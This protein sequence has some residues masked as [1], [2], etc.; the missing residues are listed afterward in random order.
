MAN[1]TLD[2]RGMT[3]QHCVNAVE[4]S[5]GALDG[6]DNVNVDLDNGKV[7]VDYD[8]SKA[9]VENIRDAIEEQ[10]YEVIPQQDQ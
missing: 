2:V 4:T 3:C 1:Q 6:V 9:T 8:D 7:K 5:V 10:G